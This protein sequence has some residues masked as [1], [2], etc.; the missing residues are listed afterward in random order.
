MLTFLHISDTH[1]S[2][3]PDYR[4]PWLPQSV[5]H[6]N[7]GIENLLKAIE[8]LPFE[9]DF[10]LH[11]GDVCAEPRPADYHCARDWLM[12][13]PQPLYLL[14]GNHDSTELM[15]D[16]LHDGT[17]LIVLRDAHVQLSGYHLVTVDTNGAG[18][19]HAPNLR[20]DQ[21]ESFAQ[22]LEATAGQ[23][24][25]VGVHHPLI[26]TD[27]PWIDEN[28][29][30]QNGARLQHLLRQHSSNLAGVFHGHIHQATNSFADGVL[31]VSCQSTWS[32][33]AAYPGLREDEAD[34]LTAGGFNL[35]MLRGNRLFVRRYSLPAIGR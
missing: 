8:L 21:F 32:N 27:I 26:E 24:V 1:I 9:I 5:P 16:I 11:T 13:F 18:D 28:M 6:P 22:N 30:V 3:N 34:T 10:I 12:Q 29:R 35:V 15:L 14:P 4:P 31:Y 23:P 33:L 7:R 19:S 20:E 2:G 17:R 25:I